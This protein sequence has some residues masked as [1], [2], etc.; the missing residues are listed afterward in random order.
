MIVC[1]HC[2]QV[3]EG[4]PLLAPGIGG[5]RGCEPGAIEITNKRGHVLGWSTPKM[6]EAFQAYKA[7]AEDAV[8]AVCV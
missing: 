4:S 5:V 7:A 6:Q 2:P 1:T 3:P 8:K